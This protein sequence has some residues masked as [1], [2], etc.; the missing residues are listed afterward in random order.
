MKKLV[1]SLGLAAALGVLPRTVRI[2]GCEPAECDE[3]EIGLTPPVSRAADLAIERV[4]RL[5]DE[6]VEPVAAGAS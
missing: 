6:L 5:L 3:A 1:L 2:L 4:Y